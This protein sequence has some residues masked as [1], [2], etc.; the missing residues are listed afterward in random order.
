MEED[1]FGFL[2]EPIW[3]DYR[4][5]L[6]TEFEKAPTPVKVKVRDLKFAD[7]WPIWLLAVPLGFLLKNKGAESIYIFV[8]LCLWCILACQLLAWI[9]Y[10]YLRRNEKKRRDLISKNV[11]DI[12]VE[13]SEYKL[14]RNQD[15]YGLCY[16]KN[17]C[18]NELLLESVFDRIARSEAETDVFIVQKGCSYGLFN[19]RIN[20]MV[21]DVKFSSIKHI[22]DDIY[23]ASSSTGEQKYNSMGDRILV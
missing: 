1:I 6:R 19:A 13:I 21:L 23:L 15:Q 16:W 12:E 20:T 7:T 10:L 11:Y 5:F 14:L 3:M 18:E 4:G 2:F 22:R 9:K 17:W 8:V